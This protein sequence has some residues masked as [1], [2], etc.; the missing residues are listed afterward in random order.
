MRIFTLLYIFF[1]T[2]LTLVEAQEINKRDLI[3]VQFDTKFRQ[4]IMTNV[5][6]S[7]EYAIGRGKGDYWDWLNNKGE[8]QSTGLGKIGKVFIK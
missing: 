4:E 5:L 1:V 7:L 8:K 2:N 3:S 6:L